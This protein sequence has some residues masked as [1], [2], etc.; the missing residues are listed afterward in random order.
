MIIWWSGR[1]WLVLAIF[2]PV[3]VIA[4]LLSKGMPYQHLT[5]TYAVA[6]FVGAAFCWFFG[7]KWNKSRIEF[8]KELGE[9]VMVEPNHSLWSIKMQYW[10]LIYAALGTYALYEAISYSPLL[11]N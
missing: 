1:G 5:A 2:I 3:F 10:G 9:E 6:S 8:D 4:A 11:P 7:R